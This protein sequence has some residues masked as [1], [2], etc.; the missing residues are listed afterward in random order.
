MLSYAIFGLKLEV[1]NAIY[2]IHVEYQ[3]TYLLFIYLVITLTINYIGSKT[4]NVLRYIGNTLLN[5]L[6]V[7]FRYC[8]RCI[9]FCSGP[10]NCRCRLLLRSSEKV[11]LQIH[12]MWVRQ[13]YNI[14]KNSIYVIY[15]NT[16]CTSLV[17]NSHLIIYHCIVTL[18]I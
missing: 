13:T 16:V 2:D 8:S 10:Y 3:Y 17:L 15:L 18:R 5:C 4:I 9:W 11:K 7:S 12:Q 1:T 14:L 6:R